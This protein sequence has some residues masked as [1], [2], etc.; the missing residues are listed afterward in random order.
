MENLNIQIAGL[1]IQ[2]RTAWPVKTDDRFLPFLREENQPWQERV[3]V[4]EADSLPEPAGPVHWDHGL[5]DVFT[6]GGKKCILHRLSDKSRPYL[7][8]IFERDCDREFRFRA[9]TGE[10]PLSVTQI[11]N[12]LSMEALFLKYGILILHSSFIRWQG[13]GILFTAPSGTGKSTQADLWA[14]DQGAEI[15]NGDRAAL[16]KSGGIWT[17]YGLP[18]AGSSNIFRNE[19]APV[20]ALV[21]L[22]QGDENRLSRPGPAEAMTK[23]FPEVALHRWDRAFL[24]RGFDLISDL[25][26]SVEVYAL[27]CLPDYE[28]VRL[29]RDAVTEA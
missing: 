27:S 29:L 14:A 16:R 5:S 18:F 3:T 1:N 23:I 13:R 6:S 4:T 12:N 22:R 7:A 26:Q 9:G 15:L 11:C 24:N 17:A 20:S 8:E 21:L 2:I 10:K 19:Q 28:A 25:L